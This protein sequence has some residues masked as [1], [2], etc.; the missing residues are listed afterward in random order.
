MKPN[1]RKSPGKRIIEGLTELVETL[2]RGRSVKRRSVV[3]SM[4]VSAS[5]RRRVRKA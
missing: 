3:R 5:K 4:E 2:E 1:K